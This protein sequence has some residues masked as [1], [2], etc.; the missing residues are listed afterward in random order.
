MTIKAINHIGVRVRDM[1]AAAE[2]YTRVFGFKAQPNKPNWLWIG[3]G[4]MVHLMPA[5]DQSDAGRDIAD[6]AR[7]FAFEVD[8]LE[9]VV[10]LLLEHGLK[11]FQAAL[12]QTQRRDLT[13]T[14]DLA[15]GIGTVFVTDHDGNLMEFVDTSRGIFADVLGTGPHP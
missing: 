14:S 13:G 5:T 7:H 6:L 3:N 2:F 10:S 4:Q 1:K 9:A 11:P 8:S 12:D 15:F